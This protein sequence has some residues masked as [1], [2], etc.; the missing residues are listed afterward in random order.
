MASKIVV[1]GLDGKEK[2]TMDLP[3]FFSIKCRKDLIKRTV[4]AYELNE[5]QPQG[6]DKQAGKRTT[7]EAWGSGFGVSRAPRNKGS[8]YPTARN[9][10]FIPG[11]VG[12]RVAHPPKVENL[13]RRKINKKERKL[14]FLNAVSATSDKELI[15]KRGHV[16]EKIKSFPMIV[17]DKIQTI[18]KTSEIQKVLRN[19]GLNEDIIRAKDGKSIRAGKGKW[20]A[21]KYK[22]R[23][24]ILIVIKE[25]FGIYKSARNL[26]G[27]DV[28]N[29]NKLNC[30]DLAPGG[31]PGRLTLWIQST[32]KEINRK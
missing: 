8:G 20:R 28:I 29:I 14:A 3:D 2:E 7:A 4:N 17:D 30:R 26:P 10:A 22:N 1:Y 15:E 27:V 6:R 12:G 16:I 31:L 19:L 24:S 18:K 23:K 11:V 25:D 9:G 32:L 21:R 5:K 13:T